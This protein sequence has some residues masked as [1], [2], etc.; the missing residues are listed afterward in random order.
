MF[1]KIIFP[2]V[3]ILCLLVGLAGCGNVQTASSAVPSVPPNSSVPPAQSAP[4]SSLPPASTPPSSSAPASS[5]P[6]SSS[7]PE[8]ESVAPEE[9]ENTEPSF[10]LP[11]TEGLLYIGYSFRLRPYSL[12]EETDESTPEGTYTFASS[13]EEVGTVD[14]DG[15]MFGAGAGVCTIT[16]TDENGGSIE[17][18][19]TVVVPPKPRQT[20][21]ATGGV[22]GGQNTNIVTI[23]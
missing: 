22:F 3:M 11:Q 1:T 15:I 16:V 4:A 14:A 19:L 9:P 18:T 7:A 6:Q 21:P 5:A 12:D 23:C 13:D 20:Q 8:A 2:V 17:Y 10:A